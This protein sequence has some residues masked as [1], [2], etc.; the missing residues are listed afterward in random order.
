M[1]GVKKNKVQVTLIQ[2]DNYGPWTSTLG[3]DREYKL[4]ILQ[5]ELYSSLQKSFAAKNGLV[6]FNKFDEML[7]VT[8][9][10][11]REEHKT[12]QTSVQE[13]F[14]FTLSMS[15]GVDATPFQAHVRASRL[16]Q[17]A[18]SAQ[19]ELRRSVLTADQTVEMDEAFAQIVHLDVDGITNLTDRIPAFETS[20]KVMRS[21]VD[22]MS[23]FSR[24]DSLLF[25]M[26]GDNF[27][28]V[29]GELTDEFIA[30]ELDQHVI[31]GL[32]LKFGVGRAQTARRAADLATM[33]LERVRQ[34]RGATYGILPRLREGR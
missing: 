3:T 25:Y 20:L 18:G 11:S 5:A 31:N 16:L 28:G 32:P 19:S 21:Y 8:N 15:I 30:H 34:N 1:I 12:I 7:A 4:Q 10:I 13:R 14:P 22:L 2:I 24:L 6:F 23:A 17:M 29:T 9:G 26:G 33:N 27:M